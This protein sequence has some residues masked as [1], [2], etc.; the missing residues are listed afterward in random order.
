MFSAENKI[1]LHQCY[2]NNKASSE[3]CFYIFTSDTNTFNF[4]NFVKK[5]SSFEMSEANYI[6][7]SVGPV[8]TAALASLVLHV[9]YSAEYSSYTSTLDPIS[10]IGQYLLDQSEAEK[11]QTKLKAKQEN[12]ENVLTAWK[13]AQNREKQ[14]RNKLAA[15]LAARVSVRR[16]QIEPEEQ[17]LV[18]EM[19]PIQE[20]TNKETPDANSEPAIKKE[21]GEAPDAQP[22][23]PAPVE[24]E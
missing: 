4:S 13:E 24:A 21:Q 17:P 18:P 12:D 6:K 1:K 11:R 14:N 8:L 3:R 10:Y 23:T 16:S 9:P 15:G 7:Q 5:T 20:S 19:K 2:S 22:E